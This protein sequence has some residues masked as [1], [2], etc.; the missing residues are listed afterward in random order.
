[1]QT[2]SQTEIAPARFAASGCSAAALRIV[3]NVTAANRRELAQKLFETA[4][5][6]VGE[7]V[8]EKDWGSG[9]WIVHKLEPPN[10]PHEPHG[11]KT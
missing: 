9:F 1:M 5:D 11:A 8:T 2:D 4:L 7:A 3:L 10:A 6:I